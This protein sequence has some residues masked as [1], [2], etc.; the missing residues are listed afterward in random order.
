MFSAV[1]LAQLVPITTCHAAIP[2]SIPFGLRPADSLANN[3]YGNSGNTGPVV[4]TSVDAALKPRLVMRPVSED[5]AD[6][7]ARIFVKRNPHLL[8]PTPRP[9]PR[10]P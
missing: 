6:S 10:V 7:A 1:A 4:A 3:P 5:P 2:C 8:G 9:T